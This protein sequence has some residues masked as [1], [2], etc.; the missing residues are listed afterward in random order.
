V[1]P[2]LKPIDIQLFNA[3]KLGQRLKDTI[4]W[5]KQRKAEFK[6]QYQA[7]QNKNN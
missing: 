5:E 6:A 2:S 1:F 4:E 7:S 3:E